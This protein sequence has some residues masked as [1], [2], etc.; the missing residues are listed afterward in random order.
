MQTNSFVLTKEAAMRWLKP[1]FALLLA[2]GFFWLLHHPVGMIPPLGK[3]LDP[4][5]GFWQNGVQNDRLMPDINLSGLKEPVKVVWGARRVPHVF[6]ANDHD[7]Y[8]VQGYL[9]ARDR[10]WQMEFQTHAAAGRLAETFG[11]GA[12]EHDRFRRRTGMV[13]AAENSMKMIQADPKS[14]EIIL[15][16]T[17]GV[18]A[19]IVGL[20]RKKLPFEYKL[21]DYKPESWSPLKCSLLVK[22]MAWDLASNSSDKDMSKVREVWG[23]QVMEQLYP[24]EPPLLEPIIPAGTQWNLP[25]DIP[26]KPEGKPTSVKV[27]SKIPSEPSP[28]K[29]SNNWA[30]SGKKTESSYPILCNDPHLGLNL[31]SIWYENQLITPDSNVY[32]VSL[33]GAPTVIIGFNPSIAW[34]LTAAVSDVV[35]WHKIEFK[36]A[37]H[38]E[39]LHDGSWKLA[40][41]RDEKII[42]RGSRAVTEKV[43]YTHHGPVVYH[44]G[45]EPFESHIPLGAAMRWT[46][47]DP[48]NELLT[49]YRLN[50]AK[51][52]EDYLEALQAFQCPPHN[53]VFANRE[54]DIALWHNGKF[55]LRWKGQGR[56]VC[57]GTDSAREWQGW[58]PWE[59]NPHVKNPLREYV[60][61]ANQKPTDPSYPYY[62]GWDYK[63]F[64]RGFRINEL[65]A[66]THNITPEFM[67]NM[68]KDTVNIRARMTVPEL[69]VIL[70]SARLNPEENRALDELKSWNFEYRVELL[71]PTIFEQFWTELTHQIWE[72]NLTHDSVRLKYP[73]KG[74]TMDLIMNHKDSLFFDDKTTDDEETLD[75]IAST[76]FQRAHQKLLEKHGPLGPNWAWGKTRPVNIFHLALIPALSRVGLETDGH[77]DVINA[78]SRVWGP[79]WRMVVAL[80]PEVKAWGIYPGGQ[81]GNPGSRY[82]DDAVEDFISGKIHPSLYL[83]SPDEQSPEI[84]GTTRFGRQ[85]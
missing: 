33:P 27:T 13:Y 56:F 80:G 4:F 66:D 73:D 83:K 31:P 39:Y 24:F 60:S 22:F 79:S 35:D 76:A 9:T 58:I 52:Y 53:F 50:R 54:G 85:K 72:D 20:T 48:S 38:R 49:F 59:Q 55:P 26:K 75:D 65:L 64:L 63:S 40:S 15:A 14:W 17:E 74:V 21:F 6:A 43:C 84:V 32:G 46:A 23:D 69:L 16:Y 47:H 18:N 67:L 28:P 70:S 11:K 34:G 5:A 45:D 41:F 8:Y 61:S 82:Y 7:L 77:P 10:L 29:G 12:L 78:L 3:F 68:Q 36:N 42:V 25:I 30:V 1:I 62:L 57:D 2:A 51:N 19:F 44:E 71:A 37:S 81:S